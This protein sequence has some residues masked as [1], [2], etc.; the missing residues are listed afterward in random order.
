MLRAT[1]TFSI[2]ALGA[3]ALSAQD[4]LAQYQTMMKAAVAANGQLRAAI[5]AKGYRGGRNRYQQRRRRLS[6]R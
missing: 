3:I 6:T 5:T 2:L 4:D 1:I